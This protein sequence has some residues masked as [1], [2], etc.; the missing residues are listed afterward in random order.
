MPVFTEF[1]L[2]QKLHQAGDKIVLLVLD[3]LGGLPM[4]Q[5][6]K[7]ELETA[8]TPNLDRMAAEGMTGLSVPI[9]PGV[10]P[11]SG[12]AHLSLFGYD[13]VKYNV[14]RG[15]L[16]T[17]GAGFVMQPGDMAARGNFCTIDADGLI[18]DRRA[19]RIG[20]DVS[21][22]L[23]A[24]LQ[25]ATGDLFPGY[26]VFVTA[27]KEHRFSLVLRGPGLGGDL[28]E[29]DPLVTGARQLLIEDLTHSADG[30]K[31]AEMLNQWMR[32]AGEVLADEHPANSCNLRGLGLAPGLPQFPTIYGM[33]AACIAVYPMYK[34]VSR[35]V[36]MNVI[37][38]EGER[39]EHEIS[40]LEKV[41]AGYDFFFIHVKKTDS[42]GED[43][44]FDAKVHEIE[45][46]DA[47]MPRI[48]ALQ[49]G[50]VIVTGDHSTP[51]AL[52]SHS[53]H[54]VPT[55]MW[56]PRV[57]TDQVQT[58]GERVAASGGMGQFHATNLIPLAMGHAGRLKRYGA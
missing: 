26:Q 10:E 11:G 54:P 56:G 58:F 45:V 57:I 34:G 42:Y 9:R 28:T 7:T 35:L 40:A 46:V 19:G 47:V 50:A 25:A 5:G 27:V 21:E 3:G 53:W 14:G 55:L 8:A 48:M 12:P 49:P 6:G 23:C 38:F 31:T 30:Q 29:T 16:E 24:K 44:N 13:P 15:V 18:T 4:Q 2:I 33:K 41:W 37:E 51:A 17:Y 1:E 20:T 22:R 39:P 36:G 32:L 52:K 43:G